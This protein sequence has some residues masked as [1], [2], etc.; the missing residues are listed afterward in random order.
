MTSP[1][2]F[3]YLFSLPFGIETIWNRLECA[4]THNTQSHLSHVTVPNKNCNLKPVS[5]KTCMTTSE[6]SIWKCIVR[7]CEGN[8]MWYSSAYY[9][10]HTSRTSFSIPWFWTHPNEHTQSLQ[11]ILDY[12]IN[13]LALSVHNF[14]NR[15]L[16]VA[17]TIV[18][19]SYYSMF[20]ALQCKQRK[21]T[22]S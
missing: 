4:R 12:L 17:V 11:P 13:A 19:N 5:A 9:L 10:L 1:I 15:I 6:V 21:F 14:K 18:K 2:K 22:E 16:I 3:L 7:T 8:A 20:S